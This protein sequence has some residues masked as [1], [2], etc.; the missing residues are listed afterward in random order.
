MPDDRTY[1][2][3]QVDAA[4]A[5]L[6]EPGRLKHAEEVVTHEDKDQNN[7]GRNVFEQ[8]KE[9]R[10]EPRTTLS[11]DA[12]QSIASDAIKRGSLKEAVE[13]YAFKHGI[14]NIDTLQQLFAG[15]PAQHE[16]CLDAAQHQC[17]EDYPVQVVEQAVRE[18]VVYSD[19][20][21]FL[22]FE[23]Q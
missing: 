12:I 4:V 8:D 16:D 10:G 23:R 11:H 9:T 22:W 14:E 13:D 18:R 21:L 2:A 15:E 6:S 7:M 20:T 5:R 17:P 3:D 19:V 1:T